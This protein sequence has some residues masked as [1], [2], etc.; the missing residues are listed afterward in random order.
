MPRTPISTAFLGFSLSLFDYPTIAKNPLPDAVASPEANVVQLRLYTSDND[1]E[2]SHWDLW[3][4]FPPP[5]NDT[6]RILAQNLAMF[7]NTHEYLRCSGSSKAGKDVDVIAGGTREEISIYSKDYPLPTW[8]RI[9]VKQG[10]V[11]SWQIRIGEDVTQQIG[12]AAIQF[13]PKHISRRKLKD[14][15]KL[16][17]KYFNSH[18]WTPHLRKL[19]DTVRLQASTE[20]RSI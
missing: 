17:Q 16:W 18:H 14:G 2:T 3:G 4:V 15:S 11:H 6:S 19:V 5:S 13:D 8:S 7:L 10:L 9:E 12:P 20:V 1:Q